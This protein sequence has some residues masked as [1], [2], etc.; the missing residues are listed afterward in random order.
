MVSF[1]VELRVWQ[2]ISMLPDMRQ[3]HQYGPFVVYF[4]RFYS[5]IFLIVLAFAGPG[6]VSWVSIFPR[7]AL[8]GAR[9]RLWRGGIAGRSHFAL[10][11]V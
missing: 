10:H 4:Y 9:F 11:W 6:S 3:S 7:V 1:R 2:R 5:W 8:C